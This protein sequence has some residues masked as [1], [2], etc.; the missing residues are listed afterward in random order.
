VEFLNSFILWWHWIVLALVLLIF[1]LLSGTF[2]VLV[3]SLA[4]LVVG[5]LA[6]LVVLTFNTQLIIWIVVSLFGVGIWYNWF[7]NKTVS[8]IGQS[9]YK[10]DT[11]G[12]VIEK[13]EP[14]LRGKVRFDEPVLGNSV[15]PVTSEEEIDIGEKVG[16]EKI[17]GQLIKVKRIEK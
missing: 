7:K 6:F 13:I 17:S 15:W 11:K 8:K 1:E 16:I 9:D 4:S 5:V 10:L 2:F 12:V 3:F 14:N